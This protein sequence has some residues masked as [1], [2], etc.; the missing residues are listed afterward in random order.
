MSRIRRPSQSTLS[1]LKT[2]SRAPDGLHGYAIIKATGLASGTLYPIL[3]RLSER[4]WLERDWVIDETEA[5]PPRRLYKLTPSGR[6][7][8]EISPTRKSVTSNLRTSS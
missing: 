7:Q 1:V 4:G 2:L 6:A 8:L 3:M 5:G